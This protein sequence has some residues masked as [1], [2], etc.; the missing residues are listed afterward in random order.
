M[1]IKQ[2]NDCE[3][4]GGNNIT[5]DTDCDKTWCLDCDDW[6]AVMRQEE[7]RPLSGSRI[8]NTSTGF[9]E[10]PTCTDRNDFPRD[11]PKSRF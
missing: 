3:V 11:L 9:V 4:C 5:W 1:K 8:K 10:N 2:V 6:A 7:T